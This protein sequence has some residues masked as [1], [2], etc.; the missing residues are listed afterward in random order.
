MSQYTGN[1]KSPSTDY[2]GG[3]TP[4]TF[5][6]RVYIVDRRHVLL[7]V[8]YQRVSGFMIRFSRKDKKE[9]DHRKLKLTVKMNKSPVLSATDAFK[10]TAC[11]SYR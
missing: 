9:L 2:R 4:K 3:E 10:N 6:L 11:L 5:L 8:E 7:V 1:K